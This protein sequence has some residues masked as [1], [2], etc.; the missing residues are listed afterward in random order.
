M[1]RQGTYLNIVVT[2][3]ALLLA[4]LLWSQFTERGPVVRS[5]YGAI[6]D[7]NG[8]PDSGAQLER[9]IRELREIRVTLEATKELM[10]NGKVQVQVTDLD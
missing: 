1:K 2:A 5:S 4:G 8:V 3:V 9:I 10:E 7:E 6:D